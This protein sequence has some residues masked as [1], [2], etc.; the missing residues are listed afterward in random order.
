M[1]CG[2]TPG[3]EELTIDHI[4][5]KSMGGKT[6]WEN[7]VLACVK[8]NSYKANR[9]PEQARMKFYRP[10]YKPFKPKFNLFKGDVRVDSWQAFLGEMY[11]F[12]SK[13]I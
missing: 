6:S 13:S 8:C 7:C 4:L 1:Y 2:D 9:T 5:P 10:D 3:T 11:F 12:S